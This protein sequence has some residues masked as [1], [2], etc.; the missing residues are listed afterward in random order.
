MYY[1]IL[2]MD[3]NKKTNKQTWKF[4]YPKTRIKDT[5]SCL[6]ARLRNLKPMRMS[7]WSE[8]APLLSDWTAVSASTV[9]LAACCVLKFK[10]RPLRSLCVFK[11]HF[12]AVQHRWRMDLPDA[13]VYAWKC[14]L[15]SQKRSVWISVQRL[16]RIV[17]E[18]EAEKKTV[19]RFPYWVWFSFRNLRSCYSGRSS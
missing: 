17:V 10:L 1:Y 14:R 6:W 13:N 12:I 16:I 7:D 8:F 3:K 15:K 18:L 9:W 11:R 2:L 4:Q 19:I 5:T